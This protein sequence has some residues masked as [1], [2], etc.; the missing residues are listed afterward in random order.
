[1]ITQQEYERQQA[2]ARFRSRCQKCGHTD[3]LIEI[4]S[5]LL[6]LTMVY[7]RR[8]ANKWGLQPTR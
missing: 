1:M 4:R 8:C 7:C 2:L 3:D 5:R 6:V